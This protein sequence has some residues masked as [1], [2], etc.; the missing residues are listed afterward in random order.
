V[1]G[2]ITALGL[3]RPVLAGHSMGGGV[4]SAVA[5]LYPDLV[6]GVVLEDP[7]WPTGYKIEVGPFPGWKDVPTW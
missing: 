2:L 4:A 1:A 7:A 6:G 3:E 5:A